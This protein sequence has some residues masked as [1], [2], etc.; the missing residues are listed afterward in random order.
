[1]TIGYLSFVLHGHLPYVLGHSYWPHGEV[2]I[3]EAATETYCPTL[4]MLTDFVEKKGYSNMLTLG[5]TPVL[6][7]QLS[8]DRFKSGFLN[9]L[10]ER[11]DVS[12]KDTDEFQ[13][14]GN[15]EFAKLSKRWSQQYSSIKEQFTERFSQDLVGGYKSLQDKKAIEI[16]TSGISHGYLPLL[17]KEETV[18]AQ[19]RAGQEIYKKR[20]GRQPSKGIWIPEM[21]YRPGYNWK[22]P[23]TGE[24]FERRGIEHYLSL[25]DVKY[26]ILNTPLL[27]EGK[28]IGEKIED[29]EVIQ[30]LWKRSETR[31]IIEQDET[32]SY[33]QPYFL[34][35]SK[36]SSS[37]TAIFI[38]DDKTGAIVWSGDIGFPGD[39]YYLEFHKKHFPSGNRY[40]RVTGTKVD[41]G[42]KKVYIPE[43]VVE[44]LDENSS[45]FA[46]IVKET[47]VQFHEENSY[48][49]IIVSPYDFELF[50][51]WWSEGVGFLDRIIQTFQEDEEIS[52]ITTGDYLSKF[53]SS[54][55]TIISLP[56][57][58][59]GKNNFHWNWINPD[60]LWCWKKIY[61][62]ENIYLQTIKLYRKN[63][64]K[65]EILKRILNQ[66]GRE[67][68]LLSAS[69]WEFLISTYSAKDYAEDRI[70][71]HYDNFKELHSMYNLRKTSETIRIGLLEKL[72]RID[73][74]A[75]TEDV[76][77][78]F[79]IPP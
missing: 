37:E 20:Y 11:I 40:W 69:D 31:E 25:N 13:A 47:L 48:A 63:N 64:G 62:C 66:M 1:M 58:S 43:K 78:W 2:M 70:N 15:D 52:T 34:A 55:K 77:E 30:Q 51:H 65:D 3:Y 39:E 49:G 16:I 74:I 32:L 14:S 73:N 19:I 54:N 57:G 9:Y 36:K 59:W 5:L 8:D 21:A 46:G 75:A 7:E 29:I 76:Y 27:N 23:I 18:Y 4:S 12:N 72:E 17:G 53:P 38:R 28:S 56:E 79:E 22:N 68:F 50:G 45:Y 24:E 60:T 26:S 41:L 67:L 6:T 71:T 44:R 42:E 61:E 35:K 33:Y 10:N